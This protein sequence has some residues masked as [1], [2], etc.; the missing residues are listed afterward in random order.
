M[1]ARIQTEAPLRKSMGFSTVS[2]QYFFPPGLVFYALQATAG[3]VTN[4][5]GCMSRQTHKSTREGAVTK[6]F[7]SAKITIIWV[8]FAC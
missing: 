2:R 7:V 4:V 8:T 5:I 1:R 6:T 3:G